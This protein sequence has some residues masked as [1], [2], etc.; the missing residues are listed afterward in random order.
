MRA[1]SG[2]AEKRLRE[3]QRRFERWRRGRRRNS[4]RIPK[5]LWELAAEAAAVCGVEQAAA[6]LEVDPARLRQWLGDGEAE[7]E[8]PDRAAASQETS[9]K[10][11]SAAFVE[12]PPFP[13][14]GMAECTLE[15]E[16]PSGRRLRI[17][18]KGPATAQALQLS[19]VLWRTPP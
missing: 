9:Q 15:A 7:R 8:R 1:G 17:S 12:L 16:E 6:G 10:P 14:G 4:G 3:V 18:L 2:T 19:Q 11:P 5:E 13:L